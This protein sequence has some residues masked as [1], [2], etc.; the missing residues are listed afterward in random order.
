VP[1]TEDTMRVP[2]SWLKEFVDIPIPIHE[3]AERLTFAGLEHY[4]DHYEGGYY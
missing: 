4:L 3:L 1:E 2:I